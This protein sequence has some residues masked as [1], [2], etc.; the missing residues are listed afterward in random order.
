MFLRSTRRWKDGKEHT[1]WSIVENRRC[2]GERIVQQT[3]L[4]LGEINDS[5]RAQWIRAIEV[6]DEDRG[7]LEQI[8]LFAAERPLPEAA[9]EGVQVRLR[10]F[11]LHRPRQWGACWLLYGKAGRIW[12]MDRGIPTEEV[13][14]EMRACDPPVQYLVGTPKGRLSKLEAELLGLD[15]QLA[16]EGVEVKLLSRT[17]E[18]YVLARSRERMA[19]ERAMRRRQLKKLW[20]R[21]AELQRMAPARDTLL[22]KL[23][24]AKSQYPGAW[25]LIEVQVAQDGTL[26]F[27]LRKDKLREVCRRE[28]RYLLRSNLCAEDPA[29]IWQ[30]Y[31]LLTHIEEAFK[32]LKGDLAV[33]PIFHREEDRIEAHIF[34]TFLAFCLHATLRQKL[35]LKAPGL[36]PRS[37]FEQLSAMQ[38]LDVHFPTTD[39]PHLDLPAPH[40]A[41]QNPETPARPARTG[42][43]PA[44]PAPNHLQP[45]NRTFACIASVV[46]TF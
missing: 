3:V 2:R 6:F 13:L 43:A 17:R 7:A 5:Q 25:R 30:L 23:G 32:T 24:A 9:P 35:R 44:T 15:W 45:P 41:Q 28:G 11:E 42:T 38:M 33:R 12:I 29:Q 21:L 40:C 4:Y 20:A 1:Y 22:L 34:V 8:K 14:A 37:V 39:G 46:K 10:E 16:R 26:G 36:T 18:L 27:W 19:K 31:I